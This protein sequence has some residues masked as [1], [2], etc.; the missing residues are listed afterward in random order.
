MLSVVEAEVMRQPA[1]LKSLVGRRLATAPAGSVFV[2]AGDSF[3]ASSIA[4]YLSSMNHIAL[5]PY[6]LVSAPALARGRKVY[7]VS[8]SGRTASNVAAAKAVK[9]LAKERTAV[10]AEAEGK[11]VEATDSAILIPYRVVPRLPGTLSFSLSLLTLLKLTGRSLNCDFSKL[12]ST[13]ER[14]SGT[15]LFSDRGSTYFLGN[16]AAYPSCLYSTLKLREILGSPAQAW[17]LEEFGHAGLFALRG[18]DTVNI[19]CVFD[20]LGLGKRMARSLGREGFRASAIAPV[21]SNPWE[22]IFYFVFLSQ[23]AV[24]ARAKSLGLEQPYFAQAHRKLA[25]SDSLIY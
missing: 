15:V 21:G 6:E 2:G 16:G 10:T 23:F 17:M 25:M 9:G 19:S 3:A 12:H 11:L 8:I 1:A 14:H 20:P 4:S 7:F 13:A 24:L 18:Q 5:D 22:Q